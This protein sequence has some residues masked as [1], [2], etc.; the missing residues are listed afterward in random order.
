MYTMQARKIN[1]LP[2]K[3]RAEDQLLQARWQTNAGG[4]ANSG[5]ALAEKSDYA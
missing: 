3:T 4:E 2:Q 5:A 1:A